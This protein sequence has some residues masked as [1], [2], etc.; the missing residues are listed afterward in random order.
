MLEKVYAQPKTVDRILASWIAGPVDRYVGWLMEQQY[1][2]RSIARRVP[3][4][5]SFGEYAKLQGVTSVDE[6][7]ASVASF[8]DAWTA[9]RCAHL[10]AEE[11]KKVGD[12]VRN[13]IQQMLQLAI[14]EF[15]GKGRKKKPENPFAKCAPQFFDYL[16]QEKGLRKGTLKV[17]LHYLRQF[18][19]YLDR[20]G[21]Q[22]M[23]HLSLVILSGFI[24]EYSSRV[25]M[26]GLRNACC[27]IR[28]FLRYLHR[29]GV[30]KKDLSK[31]I[32]SPQ[33]FRLSDIPRSISWEQVRT[34]LESVDRRSEVGKRDFAIL[35]LLV[36]YGLRGREVAMI[37]LDD[38]DWRHERLRIPDRKCS[39]STAYPLSKLVG[40]AIL[41]YMKHGRPS[42]KR[43]E[44]FFR[45]NAPVTPIGA[46]AVSSCAGRYLRKAGIRVPR[47][48]SHTLRHSCVQRLIDGDFSLKTIGDYVGHRSPSST[49]IYG[50]VSIEAL[51]QV[52]LGDGE[53]AI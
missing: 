27:V 13:P 6:L 45:S 33:R 26:S 47:P 50:K 19:E 4:C 12:S 39:H 20:I 17:Y 24:G 51:R 41:D 1:S 28:V 31:L 29:E 44:L 9:E 11:R 15:C 48:G 25:N 22:D 18:A 16:D 38:V 23:G 3:I 40:E 46:A 32:E 42:T 52:A 21:V 49:Q 10:S 30:I 7:P 5:V 36:T 53:D 8:V 37:T 35:L 34:V 43:R 2:A 14:P